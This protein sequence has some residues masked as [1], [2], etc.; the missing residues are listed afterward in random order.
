MVLG[1]TFLQEITKNQ[2]FL[3]TLK[4]AIEAAVPVPLDGGAAIKTAIVS[5]ISSLQIGNF[6][7]ILSKKSFTE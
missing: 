2:I 3:T 1:T 4:T 7:N 6:A 5:A